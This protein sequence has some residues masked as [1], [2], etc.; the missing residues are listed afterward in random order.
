MSSR[1][2]KK[3][4]PVE[5]GPDGK[6]INPYIPKYITKSPWYLTNEENNT[7]T[8]YLKHQRSKKEKK[9]EKWYSRG[10]EDDSEDIQETRKFRKGACANCGAMTH[11][12]KECLE[13][14]RKVG[15]KFSGVD[16]RPDDK[17]EELEF[18]FDAK[19]DRWNGFE[20]E[21][22]RK[23]IEEF[24]DPG[25]TED[26]EEKSRSLRVREDKAEYLKE[27]V[28]VEDFNP[29]SRTLRTEATGT[30]NERGLFE[31][32]LTDMAAEHDQLR[33]YAEAR[34]TSEDFNLH[35]ERNP[36]AA[37]MKL[38]TMKK[39]EE[40]AKE[41]KM[42]EL[43][44]L[45][46][47]QSE[48]SNP[49]KRLFVEESTPESNKIHATDDDKNSI[50]GELGKDV[51]LGGKSKYEEDQYPGNHSSVFGSHWR[52]GKWGYSCCYSILKQSYCIGDKGR[53]INK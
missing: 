8:D 17:V 19:R 48:Y 41:E 31:R 49:K 11:K 47:D 43:S 53:N 27:D 37:L 21:R 5:Y 3:Q 35:L 52:D 36:T 33:K 1:N 7:H 32:R 14:P 42:R 30:V 18:S 45:Y 15:A 50:K 22:Y 51:K 29:K 39:D 23:V 40:K 26:S 44:A 38:Q 9:E 6:E 25:V 16:I 2:T 24:Q 13:R 10:V 20:S 46:G 12:T 34:S 28:N 4:K